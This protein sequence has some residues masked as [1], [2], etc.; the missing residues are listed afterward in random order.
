MD[1]PEQ[2]PGNPAPGLPQSRDKASCRGR[3]PRG[4][5][6]SPDLEIDFQ[7]TQPT[8]E[9]QTAGGQTLEAREAGDSVSR[10]LGTSDTWIEDR[11]SRQLPT[12]E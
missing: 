5:C 11:W 3:G 12:Q 10:G 8:S 4:Y 6:L 7:V 2:G 1:A 9:G